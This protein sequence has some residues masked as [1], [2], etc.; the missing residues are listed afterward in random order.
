MAPRRRSSSSVS[1]LQIFL[2]LIVLLGACIGLAI[3]FAPRK[4]APPQTSFI[5]YEEPPVSPTQ[6]RQQTSAPPRPSREAT[7]PSSPSESDDTE[8]K[9]TFEARYQISGVV[10]DKRTQKPI[11]H[12]EITF[13]C[14][15]LQKFMEEELRKAIRKG[16]DDALQELHQKEQ[17]ISKALR[18]DTLSENDGVFAVSLHLADE[19]LVTVAA[20]GYLVHSETFTVEDDENKDQKMRF[21]LST[22]ASITGRVTESGSSKAA[23][24]VQ[25][26]ITPAER[27][28]GVPGAKLSRYTVQTDEHGDYLFDGLPPG[29]YEVMVSFQNSPYKAGKVLPYRKVTVAQPDEVVRGI[30]FTVDAAGLVWGYITTPE[31]EPI[32]HADILLCTSESAVSQALS[33]FMHKAPPL[34]DSTDEDGY[35]EIGGIPLN[36]EWR[37]Y[38]TS[39]KHSP[40]LADPFLLT[41]SHRS[42]R[43]DIYLFAGSNVYGKV[44]DDTGSAIPEA[45]IMCVPSYSSLLSPTETP[46]AF[47]ETRS[48]EAGNFEI[49]QVPAGSYQVFAQK[50]GY[51]I[52]LTGTPIFPNGYRDIQ[53]LRLQLDPVDGGDH[54]V[55]GIV[56]DTANQPID[57]ASV[58]LSG[59][60]SESIQRLSKET[61]TGAD[62]TFLFEGIEIGMY[63]L[64]VRKEGYSTRTSGRVRLDKENH[65]TLNAAGLVEGI[66]LVRE[67]GK[68]PEA[69]CEIS[70]APISIQGTISP[71]ALLNENGETTYK[72]DEE[73]RFSLMLSPGLY[74]LEARCTNFTPGRVEVEVVEG[75]RVDGVKIFLNKEGGTISGIVATQDGNSPQGA[76][77][78]L[79]ESGSA[80]ETALLTQL[81]GGERSMQVDTDGA[82]SFT[83]LPAGQYNVIAQHANYALAESGMLVL[84]EQGTLENIRITLGSGGVIEGY[85]Y[86]DG[87]PVSGAMVAAMGSASMDND[88]TDARGFYSIT[89]LAEGSYQLT[90]TTALSGDLS[91]MYDTPSVQVDVQEGMTTRYDFGQ[92]TGV[93]IE[94]QCIPGPASMLG[95]RAVLRSPGLPPVPLGESLQLTQLGQQSTGVA[96]AGGFIMEDIPP[97]EWQLDIYYLEMGGGISALNA[98]FVHT[99][100]LTVTGEEAVLPVQITITQ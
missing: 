6:P 62:G 18:R 19:Y 49:A 74:R 83:N 89:G 44:V 70:A 69:L 27:G 17:Q 48:D 42:V 30:D 40:Q 91:G 5:S 12:A 86:R 54:R 59:L 13:E 55:Y 21:E 57:G 65:I 90:M 29:A 78:V 2:T 60:A 95:G 25:I 9:E 75:E 99:E 23:P 1:T 31:Q 85:V 52:T 24:D 66:V 94:G 33:A 82:F 10:V 46:Y 15:A 56:T 96:P 87:R 11:P 58:E 80:A 22:G 53:N 51:K 61:R 16:G 93:R 72:T 14:A 68:A 34:N 84:E 36:E 97:G 41:A 73:G 79:V 4:P 26:R 43:I 8:E 37:L 45:N 7:L 92:S 32:P 50:K 76:T 20:P 81:G 64:K 71:M 28:K 88:T 77:V 3:M 100:L 67:T 38:A 35:Y 98:R 63:R 47:R 39:S